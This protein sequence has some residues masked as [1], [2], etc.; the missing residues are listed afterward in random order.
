MSSLRSFGCTK[1]DLSSEPCYVYK[2]CNY[3]SLI[4]D[5]V[6]GFRDFFEIMNRNLQTGQ[7]PVSRRPI[8]AE[9]IQV[10]EECAYLDP[11]TETAEVQRMINSH[12]IAQRNAALA[13]VRSPY[14][15]LRIKKTIFY[16]GYLLSQ[17]DS[18]RLA[19]DLLIPLL[20]P[21][22][23]E[24]STLKYMANSIVI[25]PR[26]APKS[27]LERIGGMGTKLSWQVTGT[28]CFEN[29]IWAARVSPIPS[30]ATI[31]SENHTPLIVLAVRKGSRPVDA[32]RIQN[33]HPVPAGT[34]IKFDTIIG[35]KAILRVEEHKPRDGDWESQ[36][37]NKKHKRRH[38]PERDEDVVYPRSAQNSGYEGHSQGYQSNQRSGGNHPDDNSRRGSYRGRGRGVG[39][40]RGGRGGRG[41]GR[42]GRDAPSNPYY[43]SLDDTV[44]S[45]DG[46]SGD[47]SGNE[48]G[49][50][51]MNY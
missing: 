38:H 29:K 17:A 6:A 31:Y 4:V 41:R 51:T 22:L 16:T 25:T 18:N 36:L 8:N 43:R 40:G 7:A 33:W 32:G 20:P 11:V 21:G 13:K 45:V 39:R 35:E 50:F 49:G 37:M 23:A 15:R 42:G 19:E 44:G 2:G 48:G 12:N 30:T 9:V 28:G 3:R 26:P 46:A 24:S 47:K 27:I 10:S 34:A 5:S 14:G 1:I